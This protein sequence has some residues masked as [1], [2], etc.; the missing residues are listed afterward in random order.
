MGRLAAYNSR[1]S[2]GV[3]DVGIG[4]AQFDVAMADAAA[5]AGGASQLMEQS[6]QAG[7]GGGGGGRG[8]GGGV[9]NDD[10]RLAT[11]RHLR[12]G[13]DPLGTR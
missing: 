10:T 12:Q 1:A 2:D 5:S 4:D 3:A 8:G 9:D 6:G 11:D 7:G 13:D